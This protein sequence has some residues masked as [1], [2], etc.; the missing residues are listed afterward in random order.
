MLKPAKGVMLMSDDRIKIL[1]GDTVLSVVPDQVQHWEKMGYTREAAPK[2][3]TR[4]RTAAKG[5]DE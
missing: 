3:R 2:R 4:K 5:S 1:R